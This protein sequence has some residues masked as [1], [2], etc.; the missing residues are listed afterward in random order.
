MRGQLATVPAEAR[1]ADQRG[2]ASAAG[3]AGSPSLATLPAAE[4][5]RP[6]SRPMIGCRGGVGGPAGAH[7]ASIA[8]TPFS[9]TSAARPGSAPARPG[10]RRGQ[11][12]CA[13]LSRS[14]HGR[15]ASPMASVASA[16]S[17]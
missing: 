9:P 3:P 5:A 14:S 16:G 2:P 15:A 4:A 12:A 13:A 7:A 11:A 1:A 8:P 17:A 6:T 10:R